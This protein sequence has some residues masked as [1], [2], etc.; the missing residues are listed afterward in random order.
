MKVTVKFF[1]RLRELIG[2]GT[3]ER[4]LADHSTASDLIQSLQ[5]EFPQLAKVVSRTII[6]VNREFAAMQTTL[7]EGDEVGLFPP[8]SG[9]SGTQ[10]ALTYQPISLDD[11]AAQVIKPE[12]GAV[13]VFG[14]VVRNCS[15]PKSVHALE[16]EAYE[17]MA[18]AKLRQVAQEARQQWPQIVEIAIVQRVGYLEV[19]ENAVVV[20]VS[21]PHRGDG[22][23]E[24]CQFAIN[25]LKEIVPV[26]KK[27]I[28]PDGAEWVEGAYLP[29]VS[30]A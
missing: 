29:S 17:E 27:E 4:E 6:S 28:G 5:G 20:A 14:G 21:S 9:G 24:A 25:R 11:V 8:V 13:A 1:G 7:I 16:Y 23:F 30:K 26:W 2:Q 22:C 15:G 10:F 3:L 18:V 12:T 19:G